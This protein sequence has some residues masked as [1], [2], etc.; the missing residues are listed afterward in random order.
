VAAGEKLFERPADQPAASSPLDQA[1]EKTG[2][3]PADAEKPRPESEARAV[4]QAGPSGSVQSKTG[5]QEKQTDQKILP[6]DLKEY[7]PQIIAGGV[8]V[9]F[10]GGVVLCLVRSCRTCRGEEEDDD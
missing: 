5:Q 4:P 7:L 9:L 2:Q 8:L 6:F 3:P 1:A 10:V